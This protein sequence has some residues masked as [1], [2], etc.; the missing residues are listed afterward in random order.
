MHEPQVREPLEP[1]SNGGNVGRERLDSDDQPLQLQ[2][3]EKCRLGA[4]IGA[5]VH[6]CA[7]ADKAQG[8]KRGEHMVEA[9]LGVL[10]CEASRVVVAGE[11]TWGA[12][13]VTAVQVARP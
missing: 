3:G 13:I 11:K 10:S 7:S 2:R 6:D 4:V 9:W 1:V 12:A 8:E 5:R